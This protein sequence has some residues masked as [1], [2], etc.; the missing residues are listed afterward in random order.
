MHNLVFNLKEFISAFVVLFAI[1]DIT[2]SVPVVLSLK[3]KGAIVSPLRASAYSLFTLL[4]FLFAGE[5]ILKL[6][7]VDIH[8]FAVA[9]ALIILVMAI[10]MIIGVEIFRFDTGTESSSIVPLVFPLIAGA[11][12]FTALISLRAEYNILNILL[13][14]FANM[15]VVYLVLRSLTKIEKILGKGGVYILRKFFGIILLAISVKLFTSNIAM[16]VSDVFRH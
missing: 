11:G 9:G 5:I 8:S 16:I 6:F 3:S 13:A 15:L 2:G 12:T 14:L 4:G 10:E 7:G 1:I